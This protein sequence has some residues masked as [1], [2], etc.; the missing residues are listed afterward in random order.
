MRLKHQS[1]R[2]TLPPNAENLKMNSMKRNLFLLLVGL[3]LFDYSRAQEF[4]SGISYQAVVRD[5]N[6]DELSNSSVTIEFSIRKNTFDGPVVFDESHNL[7]ETNQFGLFT[8]VIGNGVNTGMGVFTSLEEIDWND[9]HYFLEVRA[10]I[11]GQGTL[12]ILGVSQLLAVPYAL[13][14]LKAESVLNEGDGDTQNELITSVEAASENELNI[15]EGDVTNTYNVSSISY[16]TWDKSAGAVYN[17]EEKI[18]IGTSEPNSSLSLSGSF[19]AR[20]LKVNGTTYDMNV[21]NSSAEHVHVLLCDVTSGQVTI[22]LISATSCE[23]RMYKFRKYFDG[24]ST[25]NV[26]SLVPS[27]GELIDGLAAYS[28]SHSLSEY[29]TIISDGAGWF[30]IDHA[31]E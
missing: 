19:G 22:Q 15:T 30:L 27:S 26:V 11:P 6:G 5:I 9:D 1:G 3:M 21:A 20:V 4:P 17:D 23:G 28:M 16:A 12:Q 14:A 24:G 31:K 8:T 2:D 29:V 13:Y 7:I 18:G 25:T 10:V